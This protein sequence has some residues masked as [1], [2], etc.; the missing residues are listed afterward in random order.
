[1]ID[2][3]YSKKGTP[4]VHAS[5]LHRELSIETPLRIWFPRMIEYGF[6]ENQ[7]YI[8][9]FRNIQLE[10]GG[11]TKQREWLVQIDMAK[12][13]SM[14]QRTEKGKAI[15][16]YL[17]H[18][19]KK[20]EEGLLL[21]HPQ[22]NALFEICKVMGFFSVQKFFELEHYLFKN[23]PRDWWAQRARLFGYTK[24]DLEDMMKALGLKYHS[25]KQALIHIDKY[26][27]IRIATFDMFIAMGKS[28]EYSKNV[29]TFAK[30][31]SKEIKPEIYNDQ[32]ISI[33]F[34]SESQHKTI[35][36]L[37]AYKSDKTILEQFNKS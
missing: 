21:S 27:L 26:E 29:A 23:K 34:K 3:Y 31:I 16:T 35:S 19:D 9:T 8:Q 12:H 18:L 13:I 1:M 6:I 37:K 11:T 17:L 14:M 28:E 30:S 5:D 25:Q 2:I 7:D 22:M 24:E 10:Q 32:N 4:Y 36:E 15:R 33:D 20:V